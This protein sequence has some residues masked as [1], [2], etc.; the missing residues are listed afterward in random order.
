MDNELT[1]DDVR[2]LLAEVQRFCHKSIQPLV[3]RPERLIDAGEL[4]QLTELASAIGL[5]NLGAEPGAGL[6]EATGGVGWLKFSSAALRQIARTNAGVAFHFHQLA[7]GAYVRRRLAVDGSERSVVCLQG[8]FGLARCSL[9]RLLKGR[10]LDA[11]DRALLQD[12]FVAP[13][14]A[15]PQPLLFQAADDWQQLLVPCLDQELR[16]SWAVLARRD[17]QLTSLPQSHG[18]NETLTWQWQ[19]TGPPAQGA[20]SGERALTVY[21]EAFQLNAQALVA[22]ACGAVRQGYEKAQEYAVLRRQGGVPIRQHAAVRQMLART[23]SVLQTVELLREQLACSPVTLSHLGTVVAARAEAHHVL[24]AA[25][26]ESLQSLGGAGYTC[27]AGLEKIVRDCNHLRLLCGT[28]DE[29]LMFLSEWEHDVPAQRLP[30]EV[31]GPPAGCAAASSGLLPGGPSLAGHL[32]ADHP[33]SPRQAFRCFP[34]LTSGIVCYEPA[35]IWDQDTAVLPPPLAELRR[36]TREFAERELRS[37]ALDGDL[38][39]HDPQAEAAVLRSAA[40]S[41]VLFS[42]LPPPL[43]TGP[44]ALADFPLAWAATVKVEELCA[45]CGGWGLVLSAHALGMMPLLIS[46]DKKAWK[47]FLIPARQR[48]QAGTPYLFAFAITEPGAGSDVENGYGA[49]LYRPATVARRV[50]GG[51]VLNGRKQYISG[52]DIADAVT[53]FAALEG[54]G[55]E[56]WTCFLVERG[57]AGFRCLR[58]ERKMGQRASGAAELELQD[59]FVPDDH[60]IGALRTGWALNRASLTCSRLPVAATGLGI[61]RG[62]MDVAIDFVCRYRLGGKRLIDL[63][64]VQ[65]R[66]A[67]MIAETGA[68]RAMIWQHASRSAV[69]QAGAAMSKFRCSEA[70]VRVCET[71]MELLSQHGVLH[72][73]YVEK[74]FRDARLT[75]IYE[76]TNEINRLAVIEDF[77]EQL[78]K[79]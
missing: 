1:D 78:L 6:W 17:L 49:S 16:L 43:G 70:A 66:V 5:L 9:A 47:R 42:H 18:L 40:E 7:L 20:G 29:L 3:E 21:A 19:P 46:G 36:Q 14:V 77:Q 37:R 31:A 45:A 74:H 59:V 32:S 60:V 12:Y 44:S 48:A 62:A 50:E 53:V 28:P 8:R 11:D 35:W 38:R 52:G 4:A 69:T 51:W 63:Q 68:M 24:C 15:D 27:E 75:P 56:S 64:E 76:G 61:A 30:P 39:P 79:T 26:N 13:G 10:P 33:L 2:L 23:A 58:N 41:G 55:M 73:N 71:A 54:E 67:D 65:L 34:P 57:T 25:A 22:I 72:R